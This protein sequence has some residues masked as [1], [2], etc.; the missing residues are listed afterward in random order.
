MEG[1]LTP[2]PPFVFDQSS[3]N[4][5][6][7]VLSEN[8]NKWSKGFMVY[9]NACEIVK[10]ASPIQVNILLHIVGEQCREL[11][12]Q[13][14]TKGTSVE[15]ILEIFRVYFE[16]KKN[17]TVERHRF[18]MR[19]QSE[20]ESIEQYVY[21]LKKLA[22]T[23][24]FGSLCDSL[25][26][27][28]L[29]CGVTNASLRE[30]LLREADL[31]LTQTLDICRTVLVSKVYSQNIEI[32][33]VDSSCNSITERNE[34]E[35][36]NDNANVCRIQRRGMR[37]GVASRARSAS[38]G[39][40][41]MTRGAWV[42]GG[43][44]SGRGVGPARGAW[45]SGASP[46]RSRGATHR[47]PPG[48]MSRQPVGCNRCGLVHQRNQCPA[49]GKQC[50]KCSGKNHFSRMCNSSVY[51]VRESDEQVIYSL[52]NSDD[53]STTLIINDIN[54]RFKL[55]T[56]A[57]VNVLP[58]KYLSRL[59]IGHERLLTTSTKLHEYSGAQVKVL[60]K[61][62]LK[63]K[64]KDETYILEFKIA[65]VNSTPILGR[66]SCERL[67]L[68][69]RI[70]S[71]STSD[72]LPSIVQ[73]YRDVFEGLGCLPG[74]YK[75]TIDSSHTPV[76]HAP[77]KIPIPIKEQV[78]KKLEEMV[79]QGIIS[80]VE[81]PTDWVSSITIVKKANGDLR[82]CLDPKE[83]NLAIKREHFRL[84]TLDEILANL[85]GA[86]Y[87]STLDAS[88][89]FWQCQLHEDSTDYC[90]FNTPFGRYKFLRMPY[91]IC[92]ASEIFHR[93]V[94]ECFDDME[95]VCMYID[96][97][98][99][100]GNTREIHDKRL[101]DVLER[102]QKIN[103]K[104]N[105]NK[106]KFGLEE[107]K[108][109]G[110][111]ITKNGLCPDDEHVRAIVKMPKPQNAKDV[112]RF[113]GLVTYMGNFI[114]NLSTKTEPLREL[115]K[116]GIE[117]HWTD[118]HEKSLKEL[119]NS[120]VVKPVLQY[121]SMNKPIT[122]SVDASKS[123]LGAVLLQDNL[124]VCYA[125]K[126]LTK[127]E[128]QYAQIE[129][130]LYAC[131]FAC[132]K[133]YAYI[134]GRTDITIETD[135]KPLITIIK[136]PIV[137][138]PSRLQRMLLRLQPYTFKLVYKPGKQLVIADA[139]SR[140]YLPS[141]ES[142]D[143]E[144]KKDEV[145]AIHFISATQS[146]SEI[147]LLELQKESE[148]DEE[149]KVLRRY[150]KKGWP[151]NKK[152]VDKAMFPYW[153]YKNEITER[154]G[155]LWHN[156]R[157]LIPKSLRK[158]ILKKLHT[159]HLGY[160]KCLLR[161]KELY[162]WPELNN[163]LKNEI[164]NCQACL[165]Y[166][167]NNYKE[168]MIPHEIPNKPWAKVGTDLFYFNR[169]TYLLLMDYYSKFIEVVELKSTLSESIIDNLKSVFTRQGIPDIL[170]SD[171]GPQFTSKEFIQFSQEW[172]FSHV[173]SSPHHHQSNGQSERGIQ[174]VKN[175]MRK[176][177]HLGTDY[178][179]ALLEYLNT[180]ISDIIPSP[181][182]SLQTRKL[183][184]ILPDPRQ[185]IKSPKTETQLELRRKQLQYKRYYD[186]GAR[187]LTKLKVGQKVKVRDFITRKWVSG[188]ILQ[189]LRDRTYE[190]LLCTGSKIVRNRKYIILDSPQSRNTYANSFIDYD[191]I[192]PSRSREA[193]NSAPACSYRYSN[194][195]QSN[196]TNYYVTRSGR[197]VRPPERWNSALMQLTTRC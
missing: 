35:G 153:Q 123:G 110:H 18:F 34:Y 169:K 196:C 43:G 177:T 55:D 114:P 28:R 133:F 112:E 98:L 25:I 161:A 108:Y 68:V 132:E 101:K 147:Q 187:N 65:G 59:G 185:I 141:N 91:G 74:K 77:R 33:S 102:C 192:P 62:F 124:P 58:E 116:K 140:A 134:Y 75:I 138:T 42:S 38:A 168:K 139:L 193:L 121:Y 81:G 159:S 83:L 19:N 183:R 52:N 195:G 37:L 197:T 143:E 149:M 80:K 64:Y 137:D 12:D 154:Y 53:W 46:V 47:V 90:A 5:A 21:D 9:Y 118:V 14:D 71:I 135:H 164:N 86:R 7:G 13:F 61:C 104:L 49:Y 70:Y 130:E 136:K 142:N 24:D 172:C 113:L 194:Q 36:H 29:I 144:R 99:V 67:N 11:Y 8:W 4:I 27:D 115:L 188:E 56:G 39:R 72:Q 180:P 186:R 107:L 176:C 32:H 79:F 48:A 95:G 66:Q 44:G 189:V 6:T 96:D 152:Q 78:R 51:Y 106:C 173:R 16:Q 117:W 103:L 1:A 125:S 181:A 76:V 60:G 156:N 163:Q 165:T 178:R 100:Y 160:E 82:I 88:N 22:K 146:I 111:K 155:L 191:D 45:V 15:Q 167:K 179:L 166:R 31:T 128:Q 184:S 73:E 50:L 2:P 127:T 87:F 23:C 63:V 170:V 85:S 175:I 97:L 150:V 40:M 109:L 162:F 171:G 17:I 122:I 26:R 3:L 92:S 10:K 54:I 151:E 148:M 89:G 119:K 126:S 129:K 94:Y 190:I 182:E 174:I 145:E 30:R 157:I 131:V 57:D 158:N 20:H 105:L 41:M 84:P 120:L 93:K 69:K